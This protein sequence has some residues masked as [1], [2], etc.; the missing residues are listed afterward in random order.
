MIMA[1]V[2][3]DECCGF[4]ERK[5]ADATCKAGSLGRT[6]STWPT[7]PPCMEKQQRLSAGLVL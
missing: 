7:N 5:D 6:A 1:L 2:L 4:R 3:L